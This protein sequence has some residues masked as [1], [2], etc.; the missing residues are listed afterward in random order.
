MNL[1]CDGVQININLPNGIYMLQKE[2]GIGKTFLATL[3]GKLGE[4]GE[5]SASV[6]YCNGKRVTKGNLQTARII[7]YDRVDRYVSK[8]LADEME[9]LSCKS[10]I[11]MACNG[12]Y[13]DFNVSRKRAYIFYNGKDIKVTL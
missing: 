11:L 9:S 12:Y 2:G 10:I 6:T 8:S 7:M 1:S 4:C 3:L 13:K 5:S